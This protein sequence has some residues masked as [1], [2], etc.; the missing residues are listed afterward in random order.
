[1][2]QLIDGVLRKRDS[3]MSVNKAIAEIKKLYYNK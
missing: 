2:K 3:K 1:M